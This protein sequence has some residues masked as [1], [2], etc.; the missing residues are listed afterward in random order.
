MV[1]NLMTCGGF[2]SGFM[3]GCSMAWLGMVVIFFI[4]ALLRK[5]GGE[6]IGMDFN[7]M[8]ALLLSFLPYIIVI[9]LFGSFK[10]AL[11]VGIIGGIAGGYGAGHFV[12]EGEFGG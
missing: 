1:Y 4:I 8:W 6:E 2:D 7:F 5:W 12:G 3:G 9:T 11:V 10:A